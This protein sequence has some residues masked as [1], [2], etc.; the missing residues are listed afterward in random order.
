M[1][2]E[3]ELLKNAVRFFYDLQKL[4]MQAGNRAQRKARGAEACLDDEGKEFL[5]DTGQGLN[6]LEEAALKEV[7]RHCLN[8]EIYRQFVMPVRMFGPAMGG[9]LISEVDIE[10]CDKPSSLWRFC[11]LAVDK[12]SGRAER[13]VKGQKAHFS[14]RLKA[15]MIEVLGK[16]LVKAYNVDEGGNYYYTVADPK[17]RAPVVDDEGRAVLDA[18]GQPVTKRGSR[19]VYDLK[20]A[21]VYRRFYD[22]Y[23]HRKR[24]QIVPTCMLCQGSGVVMVEKKMMGRT[25][26]EEVR[27]AKKGEKEAKTCWNCQGT[28]GPVPWGTGDAHRDVAAR[29]YMVKML[30]LD[31]WKA[32]RALEGLPIRPSYAE[33]KLG[34]VH[35]QPTAA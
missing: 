29:R 13:L 17:S 2:P 1:R 28:G 26:V 20:G 19:R 8:H 34:L 27:A 32:W 22:D 35:H 30:L 12:V 21:T 9:L 15:K 7:K 10:H 24:S 4:R 3:T 25:E 11:G 16:N 33:E 6:A 5:A 23:K 31:M 18:N 14:P